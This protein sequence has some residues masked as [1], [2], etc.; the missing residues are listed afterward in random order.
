MKLSCS[1]RI[2]L[3]FF[4]AQFMAPL[5]PLQ[6]KAAEP[7]DWA[8]LMQ[9]A[10]TASGV[11]VELSNRSKTRVEM[12]VLSTWVE[13]SPESGGSGLVSR[14]HIKETL[15]GPGGVPIRSKE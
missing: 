5:S 1:Q 11:R 4:V 12:S 13:G 6:A 15:L 14:N 3:L 9:G 8:A 7:A 2:G 10:W